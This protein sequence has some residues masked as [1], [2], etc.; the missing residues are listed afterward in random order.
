MLNFA[1]L[2]AQFRRHMHMDALKDTMKERYGITT[3]DPNHIAEIMRQ[4]AIK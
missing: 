2:A 1:G 3:D 4:E